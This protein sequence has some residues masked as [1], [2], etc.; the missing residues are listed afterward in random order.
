MSVNNHLGH[1]LSRRDD[2]E[3]ILYMVIYLY[4]AQVP[5]QGLQGSPI[6]KNK[7]TAR[8]KQEITPEELSSGMPV[9]YSHYFQYVRQ[10]AFEE[11]PNYGLLINKFR[12]ALIRMG[13]RL[14]EQDY[15]W[16]HEHNPKRQAITPNANQ[17]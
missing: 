11:R 12:N 5:W 3:A 1:E 8:I 4:K 15:D 13:T 6:E 14:E 9:E 16:D 7:E 10:L 17:N 2:L